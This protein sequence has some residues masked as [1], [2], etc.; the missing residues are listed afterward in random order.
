MRIALIGFGGVGRAFV[1][2][3]HDKREFLAAQG[4][5]INLNYVI[6]S[7]GGVY[8][9]SGIDCKDLLNFTE[10]GQRLCEYPG[11]GNRDINLQRLISNKDV[12]VLVEVTPTNKETGE[13]GLTH[14]VKA[15]ENKIHVVT[16]NKGPILLAY[17]KLNNLAVRNN[18]QLCAGCT[19]GGALPSIN[20]GIFDLAG[21]SILSIEGI[22]NGTT[23]FILEEMEKNSIAYSDALKKAQQMGIAET[24]PALDVEGWDTAVKLLILTNILMVQDKTLDDI[25]VEGITGVK[26]EY[27]A[28]AKKEDKALK[29]IGKAART[30]EGVELKVS[31]EKIDRTHPLYGVNGTNKAVRYVSDTLGD[32]TVMGGASGTTPAAASLLRDILNLH[33]G[34]RFSV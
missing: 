8:N 24:D 13:P 22:L 23:N 18:V 14:I 32:L 27:I 17:R 9:P 10:K 1:K 21:S 19:T 26:P 30:K 3:L 16:A 31:L 33:R 25:Q 28:E 7:S 12:D 15:L 20:A 5:Y 6:N 29:L 11:G 34:Y 4:L 2:L